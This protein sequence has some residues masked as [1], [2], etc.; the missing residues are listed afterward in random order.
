MNFGQLSKVPSHVTNTGDMSIPDEVTGRIDL[1]TLDK[2]MHTLSEST[3]QEDID[4]AAWIEENYLY[5]PITGDN[6]PI[7]DRESFDKLSRAYKRVR[8]LTNRAQDKWPFFDRHWKK[9][10]SASTV[11]QLAQGF[12]EALGE[13]RIC[14]DCFVSAQTALSFCDCGKQCLDL[15]S[16]IANVE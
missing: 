12:P 2:I 6:R 3:D 9:E 8:Q 7:S 5:E 14:Y 13:F 15:Q 4:L 10:M 11:R 1:D 16:V